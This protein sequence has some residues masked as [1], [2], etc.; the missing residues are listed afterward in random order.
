MAEVNL[1]FL[2]K[3]SGYVFLAMLFLYLLSFLSWFYPNLESIIF[4]ALF[5]VVVILAFIKTEWAVLFLIF[6][7][8]TSH[9]GHLFEFKDLSFRLVAFFSVIII[10]LGKK[11][12]YRQPFLAL[13]SKLGFV[14]TVFLIFVVLSVWHGFLRSNKPDVLFGDTV[15]YS[16]ILLFLPLTEMLL[17]DSFKKKIL[18]IVGG[19]VIGLAFFSLFSLFLFANGIEYVH[20][21]YGY[22]WWIREALTGKVTLME[23]NFHRIATPAH[24]VILPI[25]LFYLSFL[26]IKNGLK[27][28]KIILILAILASLILLINF[29]R[30]YF[31]GIICGLLFLVLRAP[32]KRWLI[33][34]LLV[35]LVLTAEML[36]IFI[37]CSQGRAVG[38][39]VL[40]LRLGSIFEPTEELS[41]LT[42]TM[43]LGPLIN[44]LF[45]N[46]LF[47]T[48]LGASITYLDPLTGKSATTYHLDW[49]YLEMWLEL[50][51][52]GFLAFIY[53]L[54]TIFIQGWQ[55]LKE[56]SENLVHQRLIVGLM[57]GLFA[58]VI[59]SVTGPYL[60][61]GLGMSFLAFIAAY[62][63]EKKEIEQMN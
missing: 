58:L 49:G 39:E 54:I 28:R 21:S 35:L 33:F 25:F 34:T 37:L 62:F 6:E 56:G 47:G 17:Q 60:F 23:Y 16:Y 40:A 36:L 30:A 2:T 24:L 51:F 14:F 19:A 45:K 50:G 29:G 8:L 11:I 26:I 48:G 18:E 3:F 13:R 63:N 4:I 44:L 5:L 53:F 46:P 38:A 52:F 42:R 22:Y 32:L 59:A 43:R 1:K 12:F 55:K 57:A 15:N 41:G 61:H 31:L 20:G 7:F 9:G 10:W 27:G